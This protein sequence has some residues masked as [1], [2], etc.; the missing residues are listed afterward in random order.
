MEF[1]DIM[2]QCHT[3][4]REKGFWNEDRNPAE[5]A[6]LVVTEMAEYTEAVRSQS[7]LMSDHIPDFLAVE[8][9]LADAVIRIM[10]MAAGHNLLLE[11]AIIAKLE[12]NR[13]RP[14][15]HGKRF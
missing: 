4:A 13:S 11:Q 12:Y 2:T 3:I 9:E 10:D 15:K 1:S 5:M 7:T 6:M 8:E 14:H